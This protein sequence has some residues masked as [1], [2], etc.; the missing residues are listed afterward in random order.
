M[1][2]ECKSTARGTLSK[3]MRPYRFRDLR[4]SWSIYSMRR[5]VVFASRRCAIPVILTCPQSIKAV[6]KAIRETLDLN[7][8]PQKVDETTLR[9]PV[10]KC[11]H[12]LFASLVLPQLTPCTLA[13]PDLAT[14]S[15]LAKKASELAE[16]TRTSIRAAR[17][18]GQKDLKADQDNKVVG[19]S[20]ARR[21]AKQVGDD[22]AFR[23]VREGLILRRRCRRDS[24]R[25]QR[26][27]AQMKSIRY[28]RA[29]RRSSWMNEML[30]ACKTPTQPTRTPKQR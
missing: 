16:N 1:A 27:N 26:R 11:A 19:E 23:L 28:L 14:R 25:T 7:L 30:T 3:A 12:Q 17:H 10:P 13:R 18:E 15:N 5:C 2:Y 29:S 24:S 20:D 21:D 4:H 9:V 8:N 22:A 6:E